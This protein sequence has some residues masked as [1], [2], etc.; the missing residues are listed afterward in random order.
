[1]PYEANTK[2]FLMDHLGFSNYVSYVYQCSC[3]DGV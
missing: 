1:M 2:N 3:R